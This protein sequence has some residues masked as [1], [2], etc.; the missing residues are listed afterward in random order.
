[1][2]RAARPAAPSAAGRA[3]AGA[4]SAWG[5]FACVSVFSMWLG[6][7]ARCRGLALGERLEPATLGLALAVLGVALLGRR[8]PVGVPQ[9]AAR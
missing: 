5:G 8:M 7:F 4:G 6:L 9:G 1:M 2:A 3:V